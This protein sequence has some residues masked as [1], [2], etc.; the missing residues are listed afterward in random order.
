MAL[1]A[2]LRSG[3][4]A[5]RE[6]EAA[7]IA[8]L[9]SVAIGSLLMISLGIIGIYIARIYDEIKHRPRYVIAETVTSG[10]AQSP[11]AARRS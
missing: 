2:V 8:L 9:A 7:G 3:T 11:S 6:L 10:D 5:R 4:V 1:P